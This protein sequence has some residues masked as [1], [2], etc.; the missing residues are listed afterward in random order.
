VTAPRIGILLRLDET[1]GL[2]HWGRCQPLAETLAAAGA[3]PLVLVTRDSPYLQRVRA[4]GF[5]L[6]ISPSWEPPQ[7]QR[8]ARDLELQ[9]AVLDYH[10]I[11]HAQVQALR[12]L[13]IGVL[14]LAIEG[15]ELSGVDLVANPAAVPIPGVTVLSGPGAAILDEQC[16]GALAAQAQPEPGAVTLALGGS[17]LA[18]EQAGRCL[19][20]LLSCPGLERLDLFAAADLP[21]PADPRCRRH[22]LDR[23]GFLARLARTSLLKIGRASCRERVS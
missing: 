15:A 4:A 1:A 20:A 8:L 5:S 2:G 7:L 16:L 12:A 6:V 9:G 10:G 22:S 11:R 17:T 23:A 13:H 3:T 19:E 14:A 18:T 21:T